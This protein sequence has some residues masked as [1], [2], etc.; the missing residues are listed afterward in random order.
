MAEAIQGR[1]DRSMRRAL[2][3]VLVL[4]CIALVAGCGEERVSPPLA[5]SPT[6]TSQLPST[7]TRTATATPSV[8][9]IVAPPT[10]TAT[11]VPATPTA[12]LTATTSPPPASAPAVERANWVL[13]RLTVDEKIA[14]ASTGQ[15]GVPRLGVPAI[16]AS[17]GPNGVRG[18]GSGKTAFPNAQ[19]LAASW[20]TALAGRFGAALGA[21]AAGKGFNLV[22]GP[23][24]N[25]L[26]TPKWGRAAETFG[27]DPYLAGQL[28]AAEI[29]AMQRRHV[30]A[31]VKHFAANNQE[32][33]RHGR[34]LGLANFSPAVNVI[35]SER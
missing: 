8:T 17:D 5:A 21:E 10:S 28:A 7:P 27:E 2:R 9:A 34:S 33:D 11:A 35:V 12:T 15:A 20:D 6:V 19:V 22:L 24:V 30:M 14:L 32:V 23:T 26:R 3:T 29:R 4:G 13:A 1:A 25:I 16:A 31:E 18:G